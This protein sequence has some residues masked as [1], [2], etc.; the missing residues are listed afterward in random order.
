M[1]FALKKFIVGGTNGREMDMFQVSGGNVERVLRA[2]LLLS[3][4]FEVSSSAVMRR[5]AMN[6][7]L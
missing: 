1:L 2:W 4:V 5:D 6:R 7:S 3:Y